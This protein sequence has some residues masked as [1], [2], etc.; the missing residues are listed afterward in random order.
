KSCSSP[1]FFSS[2]RRHT[3][4]LSDRSSDVCSSDLWLSSSP[5][6]PELGFPINTRLQ[7]TWL[8]DGVPG[9]VAPRKRPNCTL[10]PSLALR[11]G[12]RS[13]ERRVG[14]ACS[15]RWSVEC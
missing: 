15:S 4:C 11:E 8:D 13:E 3:R 5:V 10:S 1:F 12:E 7:M 2:R 9:Q 14:K 6:I